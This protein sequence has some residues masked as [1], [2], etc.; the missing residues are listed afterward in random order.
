MDTDTVKSGQAASGG[1]ARQDAS[2]WEDVESLWYQWRGLGYEQ[3][4]LA[5][6]ETRRAGESL[7][8]MLIAGVMLAVLLLGAWLGILAAAV[9][10]LIG[11]GWPASG[12]LL[13]AVMVNLLLALVL[14]WV[15]RRKSRFLQWP[16]LVHSLQPKPAQQHLN[17]AAR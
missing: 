1:A 15:I 8:V 12:A 7:V 16:A 2:I 5:A 6:L 11:Q 10:A 14:A 13:V 3:F 9:L 4:H 17:K